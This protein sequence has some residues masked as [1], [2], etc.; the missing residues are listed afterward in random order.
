MIRLSISRSSYSY[1][2]TRQVKSKK[3]MQQDQPIKYKNTS[4]IRI[5]IQSDTG[6]GR[7]PLSQLGRAI[8]KTIAYVIALV[9]LS[10]IF[11]NTVIIASSI[12]KIYNTD[13]LEV[14]NIPQR[15]VAIVLGASVTKD[16]LAKVY[17][18]RVIT[19]LDLY[20]RGL[21]KKILIT[22]DGSG[23]YY[24]EIKPAIAY[25][26]EH[27]VPPGYIISDPLGLDTYDSISRASQ[28]YGINSAIVVTQRFHIPR[29]M[30][31]SQA[32]GIDAVGVAAP[33]ASFGSYIFG[34]VREWYARVKAFYEV[35]IL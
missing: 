23:K 22:G 16:Q 30:Y 12:D 32:F 24:D 9:I 27:N 29:A 15:D 19:A 26:V 6:S 1:F 31:I 35:N 8:L 4:Q 5:P 3:S 11:A 20:N 14:M 25:L 10:I 34:N 17:E 33:D 2:V 18:L 21:V 28:V 13:Y 7:K